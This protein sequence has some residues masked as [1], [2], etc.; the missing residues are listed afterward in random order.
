MAAVSST[1]GVNSYSR[2][3]IPLLDG[4][5]DTLY[6]AKT[7]D[8]LVHSV[9]ADLVNTRIS[10]KKNHYFKNHYY[11]K[12]NHFPSVIDKSL[13]QN[14]FLKTVNTAYSFVLRLTTCKAQKKNTEIKFEKKKY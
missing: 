3:R 12:K 7:R 11:K 2:Q 4:L 1:C 6:L 14:S 10:K 5:K 9:N 13:L 8:Y